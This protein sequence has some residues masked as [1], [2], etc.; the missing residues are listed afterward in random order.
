MTNV[1]HKYTRRE[2]IADGVLIDVSKTAAEAGIR[3]PVAVTSAVWQKVISVPDDLVGEQ[4]ESGRL[5]DVLMMFRLAANNTGGQWLSF[6]L[7]V[8]TEI[9]AA[10]ELVTLKANCG[11]GDD[12]EPVITVMLPWE[13]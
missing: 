6:Q 5:W 4:D 11:P 12:L 2:A 13:D 3:F 1:I 10:P 7:L 9:G 8:K